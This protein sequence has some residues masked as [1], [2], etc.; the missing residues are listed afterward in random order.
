VLENLVG[1]A[2]IISLVEC[3][4]HT[5]LAGVARDMSDTGDNK[6]HLRDDELQNSLDLQI[7]HASIAAC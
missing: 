6:K 5:C 4:L 2:R 3:Y 7:L 1:D